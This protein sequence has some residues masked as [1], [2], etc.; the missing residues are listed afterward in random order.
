[1]MTKP[2]TRLMREQSRLKNRRIKNLGPTWAL[3]KNVDQ[4]VDHGVFAGIAWADG[5]CT[6]AKR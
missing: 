2:L 1:M 3:W 4:T 6:P 5:N